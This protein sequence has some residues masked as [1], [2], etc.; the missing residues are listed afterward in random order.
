MSNEEK[1]KLCFLLKKS[2]KTRSKRRILGR[3]R[4]KGK[5]KRQRQKRKPWK[6]KEIN[7]TIGQTIY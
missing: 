2:S 5:P 4:E 3:K 7:H 1:N 6:K